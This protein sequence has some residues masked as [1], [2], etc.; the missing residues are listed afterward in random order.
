MILDGV[1]VLVT[2]ATDG[3]GRAMAAALADEGAAVAVTGRD[4]ARAAAVAAEIGAG[5]PG[6]VVGV[7]VD[8]RDDTAVTDGVAA[9]TDALGGIDVLVNTAG[10]GM[11]T[12]NPRFL[13][14]PGRFYD[15]DPDGFRDLMAT[16]VTGYFL[17]ARAVVPAMVAA[18]AGKVVNV[19][20]NEA[21]MRRKGF[22]PY[23][24]SRAASEAMS[25][26]MAAD[27]DGT[28]VT[29]NVVLPG[30][31]TRTGMIPDGV[32]ESA[33]AALLDP[34]VMGP[35]VVWLASNASDGVTGR[36][37]VATEWPPPDLIAV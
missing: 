4:P 8:V 24:P 36:R 15:V 22:V 29:V 30:G 5:R 32:P 25:Q 11:R 31:A 14:Q 20:I 28:G 26:I 37:I 2:G 19:S 27:L 10:I 16:N 34:A 7:G 6:R 17:M 33:R 21:T 9:V 23:G 35:P 18:G 12:V 13:S 1:R 3:L